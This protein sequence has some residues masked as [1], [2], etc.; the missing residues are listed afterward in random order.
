MNTNVISKDF[1]IN[2][3]YGWFPHYAIVSTALL[4]ACT[5]GYL[6]T[7]IVVVP[8]TWSLINSFCGI[9][10]IKSRLVPVNQLS[11]RTITR[12][13]KDTLKALHDVCTR[14]DEL[15]AAEEALH[16]AA[17]GDTADEERAA[18]AAGKRAIHPEP[19]VSEAMR[20]LRTELTAVWEAHEAAEKEGM[21]AAADILDHFQLVTEVALRQ[22]MK[23]LRLERA[24]V[25]KALRQ[26]KISQESAAEK[27]K[28][29]AVSFGERDPSSA[30][31]TKRLPTLGKLR[32]PPPPSALIEEERRNTQVGNAIYLGL[33]TRIW[34][35][36]VLQWRATVYIEGK[37]MTHKLF[38]RR[39]HMLMLI[40]LFSVLAIEFYG[41]YAAERAKTCSKD[42]QKQCANPTCLQAVCTAANLSW[43]RFV[44]PP[45]PKPGGGNTSSAPRPPRPPPPPIAGAQNG[46]TG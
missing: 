27:L 28:T 4:A 9:I 42:L 36:G 16:A 26:K 25:D 15:S 23:A 29:L 3:S 32:R 10:D 1:W 33:P 40:A 38:A 13:T 11:Q 37:P 17:A 44:P 12:F 46:T 7:C 18:G 19:V 39:L 41:F 20:A 21:D 2:P 45:P 35:L 8:L 5:G 6:T 43:K 34:A 24:A 30:D 31:K 22:D 14:I